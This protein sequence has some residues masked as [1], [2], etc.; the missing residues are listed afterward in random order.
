MQVFGPVPSRRL[1]R[2]LGINNIPAKMCTYACVYCQVGATTTMTLSR[3]ACYP[4]EDLIEEAR[5][6]LR[7]ADERRE[8]VDYL[9]LV[10][11]GEPTLDKNLGKLIIGLKTLGP[12]VAVITNATLLDD[13]RVR[14]ELAAADWVSVKIDTLDPVAWHRLNRPHGRLD[15]PRLVTGIQRFVLEYDGFLA[16]ETMLVAGFNDDPG[17]VTSVARL[18]GRLRPDCAYLAAPIRP[19]LMQ[20]I[21]PP[22]RERF[23]RAHEL[24]SAAVENVECLLHPETDDFGSTG[25]AEQDLLAITA[26]HPMRESAVRSLLARCDAGW[27]IVDRLLEKHILAATTIG[28]VTFYQRPTKRRCFDHGTGQA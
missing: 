18:L 26:V 13:P 9:S 4:P 28:G 8:Q 22:S 12:K 16:T 2:S 14:S 1:G 20:T 7:Q 3:R 5:T 11:D 10:P 24:F 6:R 21:R 25:N 27:E 17:Q 23:A 15:L 19:P